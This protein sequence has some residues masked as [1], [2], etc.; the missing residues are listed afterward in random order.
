M[1]G[2][3]CG[4][5]VG[6]CSGIGYVGWSGFIVYLLVLFVYFVKSLSSLLG[7]P[8]ALNSKRDFSNFFFS[9]I[10]Y[11]VTCV[12]PGPILQLTYFPP[13]VCAIIHCQIHSNFNKILIYQR[14]LIYKI[15]SINIATGITGVQRVPW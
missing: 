3:W 14:L 6:L 9:F 5:F 1:V 10:V 12:L 15:A 4:V 13:A 2:Q 8:R 11:R 7:L